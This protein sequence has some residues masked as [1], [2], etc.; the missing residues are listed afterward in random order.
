MTKELSGDDKKAAEGRNYRSARH[1]LTVMHEAFMT[2]VIKEYYCEHPGHARQAAD[3]GH[4]I[5]DWIEAQAEEYQTFKLWAQFLL[6]DYSAYFALRTALVTGDLKLRLAA[7]HRIPP[8]FCGYGKDRYPWLVSVQLA[9]MA[10]MTE[11]GCKALSYLFSASLGGDGFA[12]V[13]L[14][15]KQ[16]AM[17][18]LYKGALMKITRTCVRKIAVIVEARELAVSAVQEE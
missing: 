11:D 17:N 9:N 15:E 4:R 10:R 2:E 6:E 12:R 13:G 8:V 5:P 18:R 7:I 16:M 14:N 3:M 1:H